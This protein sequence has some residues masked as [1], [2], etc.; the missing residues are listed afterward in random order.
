MPVELAWQF[1]TQPEH[2]KQW[3]YA[4]PDWHCPQADNR[5]EAGGEFHY[6]MSAKDGSDS[7]DFWGTFH[8][9]E[10]GKRLEIILGDGRRM[11]VVFEG[12]EN[13][14]TVTEIFE[15]EGIHSQELQQ[16]GW[17]AILDNFRRYAEEQYEKG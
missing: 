14:T 12:R 7:F 13:S 11:S 9:I 1:W 10:P 5:L 2:V 6:I 4:S 16:A 15:P 8:R 3:N 17:Q